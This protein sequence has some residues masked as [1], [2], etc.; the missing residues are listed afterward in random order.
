VCPAPAGRGRWVGA[1]PPA[2]RAERR[3]H[4]DLILI[5]VLRLGSFPQDCTCDLRK[6]STAGDRCEPLGAD[7]VWTKRGPSLMYPRLTARCSLPLCHLACTGHSSS[8]PDGGEH[9]VDAYRG[10][11]LLPARRCSDRSRWLRCSGARCRGGVHRAAIPD[12]GFASP[13]NQ[14][15]TIL[16]VSR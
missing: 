15:Q 8:R 2:G 6:R 14:V 9:V 11:L 16:A 1:P 13:A 5:R 12:A 4:L 3:Q 10:T 7:G